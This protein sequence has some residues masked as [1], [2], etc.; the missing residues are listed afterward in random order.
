M[1]IYFCNCYLVY[2]RIK[3][4]V[5]GQKGPMGNALPTQIVSCSF[6]N[7][8][9]IDLGDLRGPNDTRQNQGR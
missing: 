5:Q 2:D 9:G 6:A 4:R 7:P 8:F 1:T 3:L